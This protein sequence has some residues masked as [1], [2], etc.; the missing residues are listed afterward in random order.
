M[1]MRGVGLL[2]LAGLVPAI[3]LERFTVTYMAAILNLFN[4]QLLQSQREY[5]RAGNPGGSRQHQKLSRRSA[6]EMR[7]RV[8][9]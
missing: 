2:V 7:L 8:E 9:F 6:I 4:H 3:S 5:L 1:P